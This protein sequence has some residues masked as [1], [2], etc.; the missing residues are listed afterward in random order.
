MLNKLASKY[1]DLSPLE[2]D[3]GRNVNPESVHKIVTNKAWYLSQ[4]KLRCCQ[5][6][7]LGP[8]SAELLNKLPYDDIIFIMS[9]KDFNKLI[10]KDCIKLTLNIYD[11]EMTEESS[12]L[13][14]TTEILIKHVLY[15][16]SLVP[17]SHQVSSIYPTV[18]RRFP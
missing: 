18:I 12:L 11:G 9:Q 3:L 10:L 16:K 1:Y 2:L 7:Y 15:L 14:T 8:E 13:K 17:K 5:N 6:T 4:V